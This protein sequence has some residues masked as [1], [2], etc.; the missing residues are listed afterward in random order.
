[1]Q[2]YVFVSTF[3]IRLKYTIIFSDQDKVTQDLS[4][5]KRLIF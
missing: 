2:M 5:I 4:D 3:F 1:M